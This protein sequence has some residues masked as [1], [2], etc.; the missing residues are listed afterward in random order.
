MLRSAFL[1]DFHGCGNQ[2]LDQIAVMITPGAG[3]VRI[4]GLGHA[5][6]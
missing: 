5:F 2:G 4:R 6:K 3:F 1:D